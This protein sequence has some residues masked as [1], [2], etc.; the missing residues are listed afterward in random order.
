MKG[1]VIPITQASEH[2]IRALTY[3]AQ[4]QGDGYQLIRDVAERIAVPAPFL[5]K[6]LQPLVAQGVLASQRGR[7]G[8]V[9]LAVP[10]AEVTLHRIV[11]SQEH[12][13]ATSTC[14]LGQAECSDE[15][16]CPVH[17]FWKQARADFQEKLLATNLDDLLRFCAD[18]P[19]SGYP[20]RAPGA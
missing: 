5:A 3:L 15:R 4:R 14:F 6:V 11:D 1:P 16:A 17:D 12:L 7:G 13:E 20:Q 8:G 2:A 19:G 18:R 9:R 10:A